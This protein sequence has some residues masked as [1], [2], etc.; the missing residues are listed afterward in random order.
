MDALKKMLE[1][2]ATHNKRITKHQEEQ[3]KSAK[4]KARKMSHK[5][6]HRKRS[7]FSNKLWS[8]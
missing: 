6:H 7:K 3:S 4:K 1:S 2:T 5:R 8:V